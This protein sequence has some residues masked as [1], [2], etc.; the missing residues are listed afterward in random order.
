MTIVSGWAW[1]AWRCTSHNHH[2]NLWTRGRHAQIA[3]S[4]VILRSYGVVTGKTT[5]EFS[6]LRYCLAL[7]TSDK[8]ASF[9]AE[10]HVHIKMGHESII[11]CIEVSVLKTR[12][13][14]GE[15]T[16]AYCGATCA[17]GFGLRSGTGSTVNS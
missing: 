1:L 12:R 16:P 9:T 11:A 7:K 3:E 13:K 17:R 15:A 4:M 6:R 10:R 2:P 14:L 5:A 8:I